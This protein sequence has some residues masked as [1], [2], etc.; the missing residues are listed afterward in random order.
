MLKVLVLHS[1]VCSLPLGWLP[2]H[3]FAQTVTLAVPFIRF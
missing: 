2:L 3:L 1:A